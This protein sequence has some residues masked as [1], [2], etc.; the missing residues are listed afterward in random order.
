MYHIIICDDEN[1]FIQYI[2]SVILKCDIC[3][4][5]VI[6]HKYNS[7]DMLMHDINMIP[8]CDLVILNVK[9]MA[10]RKQETAFCFRKHFPDAILVYC[11]EGCQPTDELFKTM[12]FRYFFK[13]YSDKRM[14][15]EMRE[16]I[17]AMKKNKS[18]I[19]IAG[20]YY[21]TFVRVKSSNILYIENCKRGS[22]IHV[23]REKMELDI[24]K[25]T[26]NKKI[27]QLYDILY[28]YEFGY[29]HNSYL[30]NLKYVD[31]MLPNGELW[32][33][34]GTILT[35]SRARLKEFRK[36]LATVMLN[37]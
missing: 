28:K 29:A 30:V 19:Y 36:A 8:R 17:Q 16:V 34:D 15:M 25:L 7:E 21:Y 2:K 10:D 27:A 11:S 6:F 12:P 26:T 14:L 5:E 23:N 1:T 24:N 33:E 18:E 20:Y 22:I 37:S 9:D 31:K 3:E 4:E 32:L 13:T 35:V